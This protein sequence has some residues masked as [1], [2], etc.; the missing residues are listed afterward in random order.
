MF[1]SSWLR[2]LQRRWFGRR[3]LRRVHIRR[4]RP[5]LEV[6]EDRLAPAVLTVNSLQDSNTLT[7]V[8]TLREAIQ[9]VDSGSTA[10]LSTQQLAQINT[11]TNPLGTDNTIVFDPSLTANGPATID[12]GIVGDD[13][14]GPS[15]L[16]V[17]APVS[18]IGPSGAN[19]LTLARDTTAAP[20]GLRLFYVAQGGSLTLEDLTLSGGLAQGGSSDE[21]G[22]AAGLGGA[23]IN[24]GSLTLLDDTV[25]GNQAIGGSSGDPDSGLGG[26]GLGGNASTGGNFNGGPPNGGDENAAGGFGGGGGWILGNG[27]FGGGGGAADG[28]GGFGGGGGNGGLGGLAGGVGGFGGGPGGSLDGFGGGGT[29]M[30]G[31]IFNYG[32]TLT[33]TNSTLT[34]NTAQGGRGSNDGSGFGGAIFNLN[35]TVAVTYGTLADNTASTSGGAIYNLGD[36]GVA[37]QAGPALPSTTATVALV[38]SILASSSNGSGD[39]VSDFVTNTNASDG[40]HT[41]TQATSGNNNLIQT[42]SGNFAGTNTLTGNPLLSALGNNGGPTD[43][44]ALLPDSPAIG[45]GDAKI[46]GLPSVDQRGFPRPSP[47]FGINP[48]DGAYQTPNTTLA[49]NNVTTPYNSGNEVLDLKATVSS[50]G[51]TVNEGDVVFT[52]NGVSSG[53]VAVSGGVATATLTLPAASLLAAGDYPNGVSASYTDAATNN[54]LPANATGDIDIATAGT[55]ITAVAANIPFNTTPQVVTL[56]ATVASP[57]GSTVNEG[58]V[59]FTVIN[60]SGANVTATADVT[61]GSA[62]TTLLLPADLVAGAYSFSASYADGSDANYGPSTAATP[63]TLTVNAAATLTTL[64]TSAVTSTYNSGAP[65]TVTLSA[66]ITSANVGHVDEGFIT[67][68]VNGT[69]LSAT[70]M[71]QNGIATA[72]L[73]LPAGFAAGAYS[74]TASYADTNNTNDALNYNT[75]TS[76]SGTLTVNAATVTTTPLNI[77]TPISTS[78]G[79]H[80]PPGQAVTLVADVTSANG[81]IVNEGAVTFTVINPNGANLT[82]TGE[83]SEGTATA[84]LTLPDH[85]APGTYVYIA[86]YADSN[87]GN[88]V[89]NYVASNGAAT[90]DPPAGSGTGTL[91]V[92]GATPGS[93][94]T[95]PAANSPPVSGPVGSLSLFAIGLGPTGIELFEVDSQGDVFAQGLFGGGLQLVNTSLQLPWAMMS[96]DRLLA[97]LA[98]DNGQN[99]LLDVFDPFLPSI[100]VAVLAALDL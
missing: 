11:T 57:S 49:L 22:G 25:T 29:G 68:A 72:T 15:A 16:L 74:L 89:P 70:G 59:T 37:A 40:V 12:L 21:G 84:T 71:V 63:G 41:G 30:G 99:Y 3:A 76:A 6:L 88:L 51:G 95:T 93:S 61:G 32:G 31:G 67:F 94:P 10:G 33:I 38:N 96:N 47:T 56:S 42:D 35:G 98:A 92:V 60:T 36:N 43:T 54:Y 85:F 23:V 7:N 97:L 58:A 4:M 19:G 77:A 86:S 2:Q 82:A 55:T 91:T 53:P 80:Q 17:T 69:N 18:I 79:P 75:S 45:A 78:S 34:G 9:V 5:R 64:L 24:A 52:A 39:P 73:T 13:T 90:V 81:G 1:A 8:L 62:T 65:Q 87:N 83:V 48:D 26:G 50:N 20:N 44:M 28:N 46:P 100:E 66:A 14:F 27:G